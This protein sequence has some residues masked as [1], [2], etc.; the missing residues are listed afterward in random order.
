MSDIKHLL[1][2]MDQFSG[3]EVG[4]KPGDQVRGTEK[5]TKKKSGEH[6]FAGRLVGAS[7]S[8]GSFLKELEQELNK[9]A[10]SAKR[11]LMREFTEFKDA[12]VQDDPQTNPIDAVTMDIPLLIR[13][14]EYSREDAKTD[15]DLHNVAERLIALGNQG[16]T[17]T[18]DQYSDIV[19]DNGIDEEVMP[20]ATP[21]AAPAAA[22]NP[23]AVAQ[24]KAQQLKQ[25]ADQKKQMDQQIAQTQQ[26]L[27]DL[28][29]QRAAMNNPANVAMPGIAGTAE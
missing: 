8:A 5:A 2:K 11:D 13:L 27:T 7:E 16:K 18:M 20:T 19:G 29:K 22:A 4:Q 21:G 9:P 25:V 17:L 23:A 1:E 10:T 12:D 3:Q 26:Q 28:K 6:P 24:L 14:L 15:M